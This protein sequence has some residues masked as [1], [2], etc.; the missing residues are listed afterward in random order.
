MDFTNHNT[1]TGL[2]FI[3]IKIYNHLTPKGSY[4]LSH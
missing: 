2:N 4:K 3:N 1:P